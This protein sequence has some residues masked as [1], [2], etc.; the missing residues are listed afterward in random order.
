MSVLVE[1]ITVVVRNDAVNRYVPGGVSKEATSQGH[2]LEKKWL[3]Q[4]ERK[5]LRELLL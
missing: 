5:K 2:E 3:S 1:A 4:I